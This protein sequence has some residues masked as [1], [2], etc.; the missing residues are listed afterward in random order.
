M[1]I[2]LLDLE[3]KD[4]A[5]SYYS[6]LVLVCNPKH[7]LPSDAYI[8]VSHS[9]TLNFALLDGGFRLIS[10]NDGLITCLVI[11]LPIHCPSHNCIACLT[12]RSSIL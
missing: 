11:I 3:D 4:L 2:V 7:Q 5:L 1:F 9:N 8:T 10:A 12:I 6:D